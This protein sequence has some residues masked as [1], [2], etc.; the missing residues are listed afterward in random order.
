MEWFEAFGRTMAL[1][2]GGLDPGDQAWPGDSG[3]GGKSRG[4]RKT[5][6]QSEDGGS[7]LPESY[8][9]KTR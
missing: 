5:L 8:R 3:L 4:G 2:A 7:S 9:G 6:G 1:A